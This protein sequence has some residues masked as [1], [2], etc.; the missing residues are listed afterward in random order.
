MPKFLSDS[1][2]GS[3]N[4]SS[5]RR[6]HYLEYILATRSIACHVTCVH[7]GTCVACIPTTHHRF[8]LTDN[9]KQSS[10]NPT[11]IAGP[12]AGFRLHFADQVLLQNTSRYTLPSR[13]GCC[14]VSPMLSITEHSV[15]PMRLRAIDWKEVF[16]RDPSRG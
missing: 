3:A 4:R 15:G 14:C 8:V 5:T 1:I 12:P 13:V 16:A 7:A 11:R 6:M 10:S 2:S 9:R